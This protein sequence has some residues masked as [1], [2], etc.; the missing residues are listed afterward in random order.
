MTKIVRRRRK[1]RQKKQNL[2]FVSQLQKLFLELFLLVSVAEFLEISEKVKKCF[3][4]SING[5]EMPIGYTFHICS[6]YYADCKLQCLMYPPRPVQPYN[7]QTD[8]ISETVSFKTKTFVAYLHHF[9][10]PRFLNSNSLK[11]Q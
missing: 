9:S 2:K 7:F 6:I 1:W 8:L 3:F 11:V 10:S 5:G 4:N